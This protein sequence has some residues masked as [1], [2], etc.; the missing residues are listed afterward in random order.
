MIAQK[1][2]SEWNYKIT[3]AFFRKILY[4]RIGKVNEKGMKKAIYSFL[5]VIPVKW[6]YGRVEKMA[7]RSQDSV[8]SG[9]NNLKD[10][11]NPDD[12]VMIQQDIPG[13]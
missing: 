11:I 4:S 1:V 3:G 8:M 6:V 12:Y 5:S 13:L 10:K 9:I 2:Y 7:S